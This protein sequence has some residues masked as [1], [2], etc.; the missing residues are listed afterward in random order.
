MV[1]YQQPQ[2]QQIVPHH[3]PEAS[4]G[5]QEENDLEIVLAKTHPK[6]AK[7]DDDVTKLLKEIEEVLL[8][9]K[10]ESLLYE[11]I[12]SEPIHPSVPKKDIPYKFE[13]PKIEP[14]K[15]KEDPKEHL[16]K[17]KYSS[18]LIANDDS[19]MLCIF[20]MTL[21]GQAMDWYNNLPEYSIKSYSQLENLFLQYFRINIKDKTS[22]TYLT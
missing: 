10:K 17:F 9:Q 5:Y 20:P 3:L 18:Y 14:F 11:I 2:Q 12:C 15:G 22:I 8:K 4:Q 21:V 1:T 16:I 19:L 7:E 6:I 13:I